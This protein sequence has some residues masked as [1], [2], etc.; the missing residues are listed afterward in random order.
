MV[1]RTY[2]PV[3]DTIT[4]SVPLGYIGKPVEIL[5]YSTSEGESEEAP[6]TRKPISREELNRICGSMSAEEGERFYEYSRRLRSE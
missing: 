5:M 2:T 6:V 4:L 1:K 3:G